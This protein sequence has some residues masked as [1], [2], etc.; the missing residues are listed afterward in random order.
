MAIVLISKYIQKILIRHILFTV[1]QPKLWTQHSLSRRKWI[2]S[3]L[4]GNLDNLWNHFHYREKNPIPWAPNYI[5]NYKS[6][7]KQLNDGEELWEDLKT[8]WLTPPSIGVKVFN[9]HTVIPQLE[10][11]LGHNALL[12]QTKFILLTLPI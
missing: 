7:L 9:S 12:K 10:A 8:Y 2:E 1:F 6:V 11:K 5:G 4:N 3:L